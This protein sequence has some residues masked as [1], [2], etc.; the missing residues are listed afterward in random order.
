MA[1]Q[2]QAVAANVESLVRIGG[3]SHMEQ[4]EGLGQQVVNPLFEDRGVIQTRAICLDF[5]KFDGEDPNGW[6]YKANQVFNY[7][8]TNPHHQDIVGLFSY[9]G[10]GLDLVSRS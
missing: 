3:K 9:G 5:A 10:E 7:H 4:L 8:H 1:Q 6:V 2:L